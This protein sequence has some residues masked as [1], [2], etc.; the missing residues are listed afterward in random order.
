MAY[1]RHAG[2]AAVDS[3]DTVRFEPSRQTYDG[4]SADTAND[5]RS[6]AH[7]WVY[8]Y[9]YSGIIVIGN[10]PKYTYKEIDTCIA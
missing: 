1:G 4:W 5:L 10:E 2:S 8:V 6:F 9:V 3:G 7:K